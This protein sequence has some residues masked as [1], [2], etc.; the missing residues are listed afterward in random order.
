MAVANVGG[1]K[2]KKKENGGSKQGRH[3]VASPTLM[4]GQDK[5]ARSCGERCYDVLCKV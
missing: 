5:K 4:L 2:G 3:V 1:V